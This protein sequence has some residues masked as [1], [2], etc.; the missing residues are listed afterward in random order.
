MIDVQNPKKIVFQEA[1]LQNNFLTRRIK[2]VQNLK[3]IG[4]LTF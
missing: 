1:Q 4:T 2:K 3:K